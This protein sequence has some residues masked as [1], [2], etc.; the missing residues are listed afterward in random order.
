MGCLSEPTRTICAATQAQSVIQ[1]GTH[2]CE[3]LQ[4]RLHGVDKIEDFE[5]TIRL[6]DRALG[7]LKKFQT[8]AIPRNYELFYAYATD[9]YDDLRA[10]IAELIAAGAGISSAQA[11]RLHNKFLSPN[12]LGRKIEVVGKQLTDEINQVLENLE[13]GCDSTD[14]FE[15]ELTLT[16][17][18]LANN[19]NPQ[20]LEKTVRLLLTSTTRMAA[21]TGRMK[22]QLKD[23]QLYIEELRHHLEFVRAETFRD[24]MT[25]IANRDC[26]DWTLESAIELAQEKKQPLCLLMCDV[27]HFKQFNDTF[28]HQIGDAVLRLVAQTISASIKGRD[29]VARYGGE[30]FAVIL[31]NTPLEAAMVVADQI[32]EAVISKELVRKSSGQRLGHVTIS[33]GVAQLHDGEREEA[34]IERADKCLYAAKDAGRNCV[35]SAVAV[36]NK[37]EQATSVA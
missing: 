23:S 13:S 4:K 7:Y 22:S 11:E 36:A 14:T 8:P 28:G 17:N 19:S 24:L 5:R 20:D 21:E 31:T 3:P 26:F 1:A 16:R 10:A 32:R 9:L 33:I 15:E 27:D 6:G 34:L 12:Q 2:C 30:E 35:K 29:L 37:P 25:G 18:N